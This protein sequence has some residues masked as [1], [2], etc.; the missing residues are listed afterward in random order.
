[1]CKTIDITEELNLISACTLAADKLRENVR[2]AGERISLEMRTIECLVAR[3]AD[4]KKA[5]FEPDDVYMQDGT[6]WRYGSSACELEKLIRNPADIDSAS[7]LS[8]AVTQWEGFRANF[9]AALRRIAR[10]RDIG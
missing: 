6:S 2:S 9:R 10:A 7:T 1:M 8:A 3:H 4:A 5:A